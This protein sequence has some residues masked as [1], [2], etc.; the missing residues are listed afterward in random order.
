MLPIK[1]YPVN[2]AFETKYIEVREK[3][4]RILS[5][6][7][8]KQLPKL[9]N[10]VRSWEWK[11]RIKSTK[12]LLDYVA[13]TRPKNILDLGCGNG[14][15][16][17][18]LARL[19]NSVHGIDVNMIELEQAARVLSGC[20]N[21]RLSYCNVL[22]DPLPEKFD[23]IVLSGTI[24]Y[25]QNMKMLM[26]ALTLLAHENAQVHIVDSPFYAAQEKGNAKN[27]SDSYY[28]AIGVPNMSN[29][30]FHH[31]WNELEGLDYEIAYIPY[32]QFKRRLLQSIG[33]KD[34]PFPWIIV[35]NLH[36][37]PKS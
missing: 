2:T 31:S 22:N 34:S 30:Y 33:I 14:W 3:E 11:Q 25:F 10:H 28:E 24:Q 37:L 32:N 1:K 27:R 26:N 23:C 13:K 16:T 5:L 18:K 6:D 35:R 21:V 8:I 7:E 4:S 36:K 12:K 20:K 15:L 29:Y 17:L 9:K 19:A